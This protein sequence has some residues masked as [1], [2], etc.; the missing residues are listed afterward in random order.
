M[1]ILKMAIKSCRILMPLQTQGLHLLA[2]LYGYVMTLISQAQGQVGTRDLPH[3]F[4]YLI[5]VERLRYEFCFL[6]L[7]TIALICNLL[8]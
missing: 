7:F 5:P 1:M 8:S 3:P 2:V 6:L 4:R